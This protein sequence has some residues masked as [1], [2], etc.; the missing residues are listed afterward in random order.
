M[1]DNGDHI[2][3]KNFGTNGRY[4]LSNHF[5]PYITQIRPCLVKRS[6]FRSFLTTVTCLW[7]FIIF[8]NFLLKTSTSLL[9]HDQLT[10]SCLWDTNIKIMLVWVLFLTKFNTCLNPSLVL[11]FLTSLAPPQNIIASFLSNYEKHPYQ[12]LSMFRCQI[13]ASPTQ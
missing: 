12:N 10:R 5:L 2:L 1:H 3:F 13:L 6:L 4:M 7:H 11:F 9:T 8:S